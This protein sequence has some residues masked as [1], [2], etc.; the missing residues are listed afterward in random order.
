MR[1]IFQLGAPAHTLGAFKNVH[2]AF[3]RHN[4]SYILSVLAVPIGLHIGNFL[5][6]YVNCYKQ[7]SLR[8]PGRPVGLWLPPP[9]ML[10]LSWAGNSCNGHRRIFLD[11]KT[12]NS[13]LHLE[14]PVCFMV[15]MSLEAYRAWFHT[16][17]QRDRPAKC[18]VHQCDQLKMFWS[19]SGAL[20]GIMWR[21][22]Q[23]SG[24]RGG[25]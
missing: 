24:G 17:T 25:T 19:H 5:I 14:L 21:R 11:E 7:A 6:H 3:W 20:S 13:S 2:R 9:L 8:R 16:Y 12:I 15:V 10:G 18:Q 1:L 23:G 22:D 4:N